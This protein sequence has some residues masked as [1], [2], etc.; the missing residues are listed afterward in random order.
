MIA[1]TPAAATIRRED[2]APRR[3]RSTLIPEALSHQLGQRARSGQIC[4]WVVPGG[5]GSLIRNAR[6]LAD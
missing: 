5:T 3:P 6:A 4:A 1:M 2:L